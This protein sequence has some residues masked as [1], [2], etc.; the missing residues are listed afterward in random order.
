MGRQISQLDKEDINQSTSAYRLTDS[1]SA[2]LS[3][4]IAR[5]R[6]DADV[7][8]VSVAA[9][10]LGMGDLVGIEQLWLGGVVV[11]QA[12][13]LGGAI[14]NAGGHQVHHAFAAALDNAFDDHQP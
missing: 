6:Q 3:M 12:I 1:R 9:R 8:R 4:K 7:A 2:T 13:E 5:S 11:G 10:H 14:M